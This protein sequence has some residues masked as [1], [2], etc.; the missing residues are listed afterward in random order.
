MAWM[1]QKNEPDA[2]PA[3]PPETKVPPARTEKREKPMEKLVN[4]GQSIEIKGEL[5]GSEDLTIEGKVK[6]KITLKEHSLTVGA[7]GRIEGEVIAKSIVIVGELTGNVTADDRVEVASTGSMEGDIVAPRVVLADG[8]R[9]KGSI[10]MEQKKG[11][12]PTQT[13]MK[14]A[15]P[16]SEPPRGVPVKS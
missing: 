13:P 6:G 15:A 11:S 10:D 12:A 7:N 14:T 9:F 16:A 5:N 4:I 2:V 8:A 3:A 1:R